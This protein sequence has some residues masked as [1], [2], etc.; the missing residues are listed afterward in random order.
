V[1]FARPQVKKEESKNKMSGGQRV[2]SACEA[3]QIL[4][5]SEKS[6]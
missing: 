4:K 5:P 3:G 2:V 1:R 6:D